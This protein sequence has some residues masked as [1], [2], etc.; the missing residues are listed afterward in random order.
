MHNRS[1][2]VYGA[3]S[4]CVAVILA[5]GMQPVVVL[6]GRVLVCPE[7]NIPEGPEP[8]NEGA[9]AE[10][11]DRQIRITADSFCGFSVAGEVLAFE[12]DGVIT[13]LRVS[14]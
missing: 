2:I 4:H 10:L 13:Y 5:V 3:G 7:T 12:V 9:V 11:F 8:R 1:Q 6:F 14:V